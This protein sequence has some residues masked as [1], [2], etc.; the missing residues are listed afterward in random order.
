MAPVITMGGL[1]SFARD[2]GPGGIPTLQVI[3]HFV[4]ALD[5]EGQTLWSRI[6]MGAAVDLEHGCEREASTRPQKS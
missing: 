3:S 2:P 6:Q 5:A 4:D 1:S